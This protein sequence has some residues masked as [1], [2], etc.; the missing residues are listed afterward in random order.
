MPSGYPTRRMARKSFGSDRLDR[1]F[2]AT[3]AALVADA[4]S[5]DNAQTLPV[6]VDTARLAWIIHE[7]IH[8]I[9]LAADG[10]LVGSKSPLWTPKAALRPLLPVYRGGCSAR[11][12]QSD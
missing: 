4:P 6:Q 2:G 12:G 3:A 9:G 7:N 8:R 1:M 5:E 11:C 10:G